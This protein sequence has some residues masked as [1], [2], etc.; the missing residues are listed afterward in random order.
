MAS[1]GSVHI[2]TTVSTQVNGKVGSWFTPDVMDFTIDV[3]KY[4]LDLSGITSL[5][6]ELKRC[7]RAHVLLSSSDVRISSEPMFEIDIGFDTYETYIIYRADDSLDSGSRIFSKFLTPNIFN[8]TVY[9]PFWISWADGEIKLG[10]GIVVDENVLGYLTNAPQFEVKAIG[11]LTTYG[12]LG[13]W[14]I[15]FEGV[16]IT[17]IVTTKVNDQVGSWGTA[18]VMDY[19]IDVNKYNLDLSGITSLVFELKRCGRA[20]VLLSSSDVRNSAKP[21][22]EFDIGN[23]DYSTYIIYRSDDL[24]DPESRNY[25]DFLTPNIYDCTVYL[26][27]WISWAEGEIKLGTGIVVGKNVLGYLT[28]SPH[29]EVKAIGVLTDYGRLGNWRIYFED[30]Y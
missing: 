25:V 8:C 1:S 6:F 23:K 20:H 10:T 4:K 21:L 3:N 7:G 11:V 19:T 22:Y 5:V 9:L 18:D 24:L 16:Y 13:S 26:P 12:M 28:N 15:Q 27:F 17:T 30:I 14:R 29:F 2:T